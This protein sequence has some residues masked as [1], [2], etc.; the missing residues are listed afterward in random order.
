M[1]MT[2]GEEVCVEE[3]V[4]S[5]EDDEVVEGVVTEEVELVIG[6]VLDSDGV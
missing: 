1:V 5:L 6:T 3:V 2:T 4:L